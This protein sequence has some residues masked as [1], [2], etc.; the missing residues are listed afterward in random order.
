M[1][2]PT[3]SIHR[4]LTLVLA[5]VLF[6]ASGA[7]PKPQSGGFDTPA[8]F[9]AKDILPP[10]LVKGEHFQVLD[11]VT[12]FESLHQFK[13]QTDWGTLDVYGE[14]LLRIRL[15]EVEALHRLENTSGVYIA[16]KAAVDTATKSVK[17][18]G[19]AIA[20]PVETVKAVPGGTAIL[21]ANENHCYWQG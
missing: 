14:S 19:T 12:T 9:A 2:I 16:G 18:L 11:G 21:N 8:V 5:G 4:Y 13:V 6:S 10:A 15:K 3:R 17:S 1:V 20:H 7:Y